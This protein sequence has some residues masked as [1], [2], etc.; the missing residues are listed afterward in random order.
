[1]ST[2]ANIESEIESLKVQIAPLKANLDAKIKQVAAAMAPTAESWMKAE[3]NRAVEANAHKI[4]GGELEV[5]P[6]K[7]DFSALLAKVPELCQSAISDDYNWPHTLTIAGKRDESRHGDYF[8][9]AYRKVVSNLGNIL[10]THR[11]VDFNKSGN[12][13]ELTPGG[14]RYK[15]GLGPQQPSGPRIEYDDMHKTLKSLT[16]R[17]RM[18]DD[19]LVKAKARAVWDSK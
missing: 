2:I 7:Q 16:S 18:L 5:H 17:L 12:A 3:M 13:W 14:A 6:I 4:A 19:D 1:M 10:K 9:T 15:Y 8:D 11:L